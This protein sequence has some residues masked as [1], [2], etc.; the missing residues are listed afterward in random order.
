MA[1]GKEKIVA[2][3]IKRVKKAIEKGSNPLS[4]GERNLLLDSECQR[5]R[6]D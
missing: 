4:E 2:G 3:G 6:E 1:P 5:E